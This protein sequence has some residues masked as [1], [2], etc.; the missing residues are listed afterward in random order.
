[1][2][3]VAE[4]EWEGLLFGGKRC[5]NNNNKCSSWSLVNSKEG[6]CGRLMVKHLK[7]LDGGDHRLVN[8]RGSYNRWR[9]GDKQNGTTLWALLMQ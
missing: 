6:C 5:F 4:N 3:A 9:W 1:M 2:A 7:S 8:E